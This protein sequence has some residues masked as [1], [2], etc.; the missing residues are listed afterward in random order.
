[1][2]VRH[3][4]FITGSA[5]LLLLFG[6]SVDAVGLT[7]NKVC[8]VEALSS[9]DDSMTVGELRELCRPLCDLDAEPQYRHRAGAARHSRDKL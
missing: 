4:N 6:V 2:C 9:A 5:I 1:M 3:Y 8:L 7:T